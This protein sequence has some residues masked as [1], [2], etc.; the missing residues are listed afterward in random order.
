MNLTLNMMKTLLYHIEIKNDNILAQ[1]ILEF[2][3]A[4]SGKKFDLKKNPILFMIYFCIFIA[5]LFLGY[6]LFKNF[7]PFFLS[8]ILWNIGSYMVFIICIGGIV[9]NIIHGAPFAKF[10]RDGNIIEWIHSGQR[11]QY[12]G[13]G[14]FMSSLFV[15]AGLTMALLTCLPKYVQSDWNLRIISLVVI[16]L[17]AIFSKM[18]IW[19]Y[20]KKAPWYGPT[21]YPPGGYIQGP[22]IK[23]Q[24]NS[25]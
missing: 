15:V 20:Q 5:L 17:A 14:V 7:K 9:Y 23:D 3:N 16:F 1:K 6:N 25:F 22:L 12:V 24:G 19:V 11:S 2:A 21:Y 18:V 10:D 4:K 8:P 13:E